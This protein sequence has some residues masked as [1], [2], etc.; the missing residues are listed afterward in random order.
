MSARRLER[1]S[2][3]GSARA[4][5]YRKPYAHFDVSR[6]V[7][8]VERVSGASVLCPS[9]CVRACVCA[10]VSCHLIFVVRE[11]AMKMIHEVI[12]T[13]ACGACGCVCVWMCVRACELSNQLI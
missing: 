2:S 6:F 1:V 3:F 10:C 7:E 12:T 13:L 5:A 4:L 11:C 9:V 8:C